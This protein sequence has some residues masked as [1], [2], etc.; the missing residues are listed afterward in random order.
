SG[1]VT[2]LASFVRQ[3]DARSL[4]LIDEIGAGTD[5]E[6]GAALGAAILEALLE[7]GARGIITTH[8]GALKAFAY[9]RE[10]V[11]NA[12]VE[13]CLETLRPKYRLV[14]GVPGAS[15]ALEVAR[16]FGMPEDVVK[17]AEEIRGQ[18]GVGEAE[19]IDT[20]QRLR[21]D[22]EHQR[23]QARETLE[24]AEAERQAAET[25]RVRL[26]RT[27]AALEVESDSVLRDLYQVLRQ[28][29]VRAK[30]RAEGM[31]Q[32]ARL[33]VGG[34]ARDLEGPLE[35]T[36][37]AERRRQFADRLRKNARVYCVS[38]GREGVVTRIH[39][40]KQRITLRIDGKKIETDFDDVSWIAT[41]GAGAAADEALKPR[42]KVSDEGAILHPDG[43]KR[44][45]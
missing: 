29:L 12:S 30:K 26:E 41:P 44:W 18:R 19:L 33:L 42:K 17:R 13:F 45:V 4:V 6:E 31:P 9:S 32:E 15:H 40:G 5:P 23:E 25:E 34:L 35:H 14:V 38:F 22:A 1:H 2:E 39:K 8:L 16:R 28:G 27:R 37:F 10:R 36:P 24:E 21:I 43:R 3:A 11:E 20:V 7:R